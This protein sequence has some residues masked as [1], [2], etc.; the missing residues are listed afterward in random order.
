MIHCNLIFMTK[1]MF[2]CLFSYFLSKENKWKY[3]IH[4]SYILFCKKK[5][6]NGKAKV[7]VIIHAHLIKS[8]V[9][10]SC[11]KSLK[12][13]DID[14]SMPNQI[15]RIEKFKKKKRKRVK[16]K[17]TAILNCFKS[18]SWIHW[19]LINFLFSISFFEYLYP[20]FPP[21]LNQVQLS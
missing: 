21:Y 12:L 1:R 9:L 17:L 4:I 2:C 13:I 3:I 6:N 5:E 14:E 8:F 11:V 16:S 20:L 18:T 15:F 19:I 10:M 7:L